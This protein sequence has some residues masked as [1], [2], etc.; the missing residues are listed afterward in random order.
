M[1]GTQ[2]MATMFQTVTIKSLY[3]HVG[4]KRVV[5]SDVDGVVVGFDKSEDGSTLTMVKYFRIKGKRTISNV[6]YLRDDE[7]TVKE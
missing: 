3:N 7:F 5:A 1:K 2:I 4:A 6:T